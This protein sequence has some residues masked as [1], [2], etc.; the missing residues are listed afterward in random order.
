MD[1]DDVPLPPSGLAIPVTLPPALARLRRRHDRAAS[2]GAQPHVTVLYPFI[3]CVSLSPAIRDE[4]AVVAGSIEPFTVRFA[5]V[6]RFE[7]V[8]WIEPEPAEPFLT[9]TAA[10]VARWPDYPPYGG[11]FDTVIPH[12]TIAESD[13]AP[14]AEIE[15]EAA[16][17]LP[18]S[19][20]VGRL[21]LWC[22]DEA[23]GWRPR[24]QW[25]LGTARGDGAVQPRSR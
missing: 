4:L 17:A 12:L 21:E 20:P 15:A 9:L 2:A 25:P 24:W 23:G 7:G 8:V 18:F 13:V 3:P 11:L 1:P 16:R 22:Q 14:L 5:A 6:R 10:V 19:A